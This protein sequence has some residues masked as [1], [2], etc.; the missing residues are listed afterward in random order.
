MNLEQGQKI[1]NLKDRIVANFTRENWVE[2]GLLTGFHDLING[3]SR[4]LRSLAWGD[5]DYTD[6][7]INVLTGMTTQN[8]S[9]LSAIEDYL[10]TKYEEETIYVSARPAERK[11]TFSPS[12]FEIP[13]TPVEADLVAVMMPF[14]VSM[15][16]VYETIR[17]S[18]IFAGYRALRADDIWDNSV[19][20]QDIFSLIYRSSVVVVDFTGKNPNVMYE[21]GIAHTL[22]KLV[23]PISQSLE[24]TPFD[25][26]HHRVLT[27][28]PNQEGLQAL[29]NSLGPK[30]QNIRA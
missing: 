5:E 2:L 25:M 9:V 7:V 16:G 19:I 3:H 10:N 6:N 1:L 26:R 24:D 28:Y 4:L 14:D 22:G 11:I 18:C 20:I 21:T 27:Y 29:A 15:A 30:L 8:P 17:N 13:N 12:V 23:I